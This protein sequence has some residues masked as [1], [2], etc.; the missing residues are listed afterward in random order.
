MPSMHMAVS[1]E[2]ATVGNESGTG[3]ERVIQGA[4]PASKIVT[5]F[6]S[7]H[8]LCHLVGWLP[9]HG[10]ALCAEVR[11]AKGSGVGSIQFPENSL[12]EGHLISVASIQEQMDGLGKYYAKWK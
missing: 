3:G 10:S 12:T 4:E 5:F 6:M 7:C 1:V 8:F 11:T 2:A 9:R